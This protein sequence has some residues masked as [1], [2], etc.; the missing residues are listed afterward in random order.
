MFPY[1]DS[2]LILVLPALLFA[3]W[4]QLRVKLTF[5]RYSRVKTRQGV[6]AD[7]VARMLLD[8]FGLTSVPI[9]RVRGQL[10]DHYDPRAKS[11]SLSDSVYGSSSIAAIGVAAHEVG[12]AIQ[13]STDYAPLEIRNGIVPV[14]SIASSMA[15]PL[16]FFGLIL[17]GPVL[18]DLGIFLFLGVVIF[19]LVTL[20]VEF[21]ASSRAMVVLAQ[22]G[23]LGSDELQGARKVLNAAAWTYIAATLMAVLQL[24]RLLVLRNS[25]DR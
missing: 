12:H 4:A 11:L 15:I 21:N 14:V 18:M 5:E 23:A 22:T 13:N 8:R 24:V 20:P 6:T 16:F 25:R 7:Q 2:T 9:N 1:F 19:H 3:G 10:T 17:R